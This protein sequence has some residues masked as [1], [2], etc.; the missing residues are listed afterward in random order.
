[1]K[2]LVNKNNPAFRIIAPEIIEEE[3]YYTLDG[4]IVY[5]KEYWTL[6]EEEPVDLEK[7]AEELIEERA[8]LNPNTPWDIDDM[9]WAITAG[10]KWMAEQGVSYETELIWEIDGDRAFPE[11]DPPVTDLMVPGEISLN[12]N[13]EDKVI[14]QIR[15]AK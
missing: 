7:A 9:R 14:V 4:E 15:K 2:T 13:D 1:M 8:K 5:L 3:E 11:L 10:A 12:F 6:V